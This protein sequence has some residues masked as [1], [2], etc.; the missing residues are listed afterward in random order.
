MQETNVN[1][2]INYKASVS[3]EE[4]KESKAWGASSFINLFG[5][6]SD[7]IKSFRDIHD[8]SVALCKAIDM[9]KYGS[10]MIER[11]AEGYY[12]G[13][14]LLQFIE[15]SSITAHFDEQENRAFIDIFSCKYF[16]G[17]EAAKFC[18]DFFKADSYEVG[19][20]IRK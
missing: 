15:T 11:F 20:V 9:K 12:E 16:N 19:T 2:N 6:D 3:R 4:Y 14:S 8:F 17:E 5:C 13:C 10:P 1:K 7:M 18:Q